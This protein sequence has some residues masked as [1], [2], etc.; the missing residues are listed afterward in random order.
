MKLSGILTRRETDLVGTTGPARVQ[1]RRKG[2]RD[3]VRRVKPG[4]IVVLDQVDL[5]ARVAEALV[6]AGVVGVVDLAPAVSGR[7]PNRGPEILLAAGVALVDGVAEPLLDEVRDGARLRL[8]EGGVFV[9]DREV[10]RGEQQ[11]ADSV[12]DQLVE[13]QAGMSAQLEAFSSDAV[14]FLRKDRTLILDGIGVPE[15]AT[16]VTDR[17]VLVVSAMEGDRSVVRDELRR[18]KKY[19]AEQ[20]PV[21]IGVEAGADLL[22][23]AGHRPD[24]VVADPERVDPETLRCAGEIVLPADLEGRASGAGRVQELGLDAVTFPAAATSEDLALL[25][26]DTH[27]AALVVAVGF[28]ASLSDFLD[29]GRSA[30]NPS[31]FLTRLRLGDKLVGPGAVVALR[32]RRRSPVGVIVLLLVVLALAGAAFAVWEYGAPVL[33]LDSGKALVAGFRGL[34]G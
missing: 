10:G 16:L 22:R 17:H 2:V 9:G 21:L 4:E 24:V 19:V 12:A 30:S 5:D 11:D 14:E 15:L 8:H 18:L 29:R 27:E 20:G 7:F 1:R 28:R 25:L 26:A 31:T 33:V 3:L 32:Q 34:F 13:A 6:E 23:G